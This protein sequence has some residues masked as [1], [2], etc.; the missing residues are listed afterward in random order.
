MLTS[1]GAAIKGTAT[2]GAYGAAKAVMNSLARTVAV[3]EPEVTVIAIR[4]GIVET[5]MQN[6]LRDEH[7]GKMDEVD[8]ETRRVSCEGVC[9][10]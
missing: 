6:T 4:P 8:V 5:E 7:Y 9:R 1:S 2:W 3:E 10:R